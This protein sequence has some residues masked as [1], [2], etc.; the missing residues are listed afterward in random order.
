MARR[1]TACRRL[2]TGRTER[3]AFG[4]RSKIVRL[5]DIPPLS[6]T[7]RDLHRMDAVG[8]LH[9]T[10]AKQRFLG[11]GPKKQGT[12]TRPGS[13][14]VLQDRESHRRHDDKSD[15][16]YHM[17]GDG[18]AH[19][20]SIVPYQAQNDSSEQQKRQSSR[21]IICVR[22]P[23]KTTCKQRSWPD[24][25]RRAQRCPKPSSKEQLLADWCEQRNTTNT[26]LLYMTVTRH[27]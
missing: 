9:P 26:S 21:L 3:A 16:L 6:C 14:S 17:D 19:A 5:N 10:P 8:G 18:R 20:A 27:T 2:P 15:V 1:I 24:S 22:Y 4:R 11:R 13:R 12:T 25:P 23:P 7:T